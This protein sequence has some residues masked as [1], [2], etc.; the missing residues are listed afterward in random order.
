MSPPAR[1]SSGGPPGGGRSLKRRLRTG[2]GRSVSSA[3]WLTRQLNDPYVAA[4]KRQGY[5]AR[6]AFKLA[7]IDDKLALIQRGDRIL[8]L[9]AAP[10]GWAQVALERAGPK[11]R[12]VGLDLLEIAPFAGA[13]FL[14]GDVCD[15]G[16]AP[17]LAAALG[18]PADLVLSDM[19]APSSGH[20][21][22][23]H[24]RTM[25]LV[26]AALELAEE[27]L[28]P[29]GRFLAKVLQGGTEATLLARLKRDFAKVRHI[30]PPASRKESRELYVAAL[31]FRGGGG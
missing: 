29:G 16:V 15:P 5:R 21:A 19:A 9:G 20:G 17:R 25:A 31:G 6:S 3:R 1:G 27:L 11:G 26:E 4:A 18:G 8:D 10:G 30:K 28:A 14:L 2:R 12:L 13:T 22:T 24:L 7:E 23:D